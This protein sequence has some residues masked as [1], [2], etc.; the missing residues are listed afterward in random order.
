MLKEPPRLET[1]DSLFG[2][3]Y[4]EGTSDLFDFLK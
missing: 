2:S 4:N 1:E 3:E